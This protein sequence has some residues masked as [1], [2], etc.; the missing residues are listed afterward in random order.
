M[1]VQKIFIAAKTCLQRI[2]K[3]LFVITTKN[4]RPQ[5]SVS[6]RENSPS[7]N[8][9]KLGSG[10]VG[11]KLAQNSSLIY[12]LRGLR[13]LGSAPLRK[14]R[15]TS[16]T[17]ELDWIF[18]AEMI[19]SRREFTAGMG[20]LLSE[21]LDLNAQCSQLSFAMAERFEFGALENDELVG[22]RVDEIELENSALARFL[23]QRAPIRS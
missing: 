7:S 23:C 21:L 19:F 4:C 13:R 9:V 15:F 14:V 8:N 2:Y 3:S 11:E 22:R 20:R 6:D 1:N 5:S 10:F 16:K 12:A 18:E 17:I